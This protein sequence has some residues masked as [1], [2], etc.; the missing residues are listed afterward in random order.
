VQL[1]QKIQELRRRINTLRAQLELKDEPQ[2]QEQ[3][4]RPSAADLYKAKLL[5]NKNK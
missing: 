3:E 1:E 5:G 4:R 2:L